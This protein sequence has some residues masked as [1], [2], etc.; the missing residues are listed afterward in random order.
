[1]NW[2]TCLSVSQGRNV[3]EA[4]LFMVEVALIVCNACMTLESA[5]RII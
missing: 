4:L 5:F 3:C 1:M 2:L